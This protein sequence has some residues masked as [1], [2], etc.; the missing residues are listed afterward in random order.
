MIDMLEGVLRRPKT[1][2]VL[3]LALLVAG[4]F[5]YISIPKEDSPDIDVPIFYVSVGQQGISPEDAERLLVRP[6]ETELRGLDGLKEITA[7][8]SEGHAAIILEFDISFDKDE[9]LS[10]VRDKVDAAKGELPA[11]A[12]EPTITETNFAL[13]PTITIALSGSVP[14]RTLYQHARRLKDVVEAIDTV[15]S[16]DLKGHREELLE[17]LIDSQKL[18]SYAITQQELLASLSENNQLVPAGYIDGGQGR[19]N[20][21]VPGLVETALDVY[22]LPIKQSGEGVVTLRDVAD[23]RRTFKDADSYTRVNGQPAIALDVTKRIGTNIIENNIAIRAAVDEATKDWPET[24]QVDYM[25][26]MSSNIFE[27]LGSLQSSIMTA[28]F[29][30]MILVLAALGLRS[31][32]LVGLAIPTSFMVGFLILSGLGYTVNIMV[33]F[34]LVLTVGML[35]DGAIVMV[36]YA[37]RKVSEGMEDREAFIRAARLMFWPIVSSTATTLVAFLPMLLWPGVAGEFMSY[38]PIMVIIVLTAALLTAMVFLPVTGGIFA[39]ITHFLNRYAAAVLAVLIAAVS[40]VA[41]LGFFGVQ[42]GSPEFGA[43][44]SAAPLAIPAAALVLLGVGIGSFLVLRPFVRRRKERTALQVDIESEKPLKRYRSVTFVSLAFEAV[45]VGFGAYFAFFLLSTRPDIVVGPITSVFVFLSGL[46]QPLAA[47]SNPIAIDVGFYLVVAGLTLL[48]IWAGYQAISPLVHLCERLFGGVRTKLGFNAED[49]R[50]ETAKPDDLRFDPSTA[51]GFTGLYVRHLKLLAGNPIG[52]VLTIVAVLGACAYI[53]TSFATNPTG[54]EFFVD[55]EPDQAV[56]LVS[57]RGNMS[58]LESFEIV[59]QVEAEVLQTTGIQNVITSAFPPGG[60]SGPDFIGGVQDKP[61]DVIG[62]MTLELAKYCC[63]RTAAEIFAEIRDRTADIP[64]VKVETRKIEGGPPTG[65]DIQLEVKSTDYD[66]MVAEVARIRAHLDQME[67][68]LDQEDDR[69]LPGIEWQIAIDREQA[70]RYQA[71]IGSVGAM[72]QLVTNGVLI[73]K[74]RPTDSE[75]EVDIRVRLPSDERTLD[76]FDQLRLQ[77]PLGLVP[78]ANFVDRAPEPKVSSITRRDGLYSMMLKATVDKAAMDEDGKPITVDAKVQELT[79]W[80][81]SQAFPDNVYLQFRGADEDQKES[82]EFLMRAMM[83]SLFLMF[84]ILLT[85]FNSFYQTFL[86]LSTVV[87]SVMGVLLGMMLTGQKF[88]IIM[89][90]TGIVALAGIV[91]NNAIVLIDTYNRFRHDGFEPL[92]AILKTSGQRIRP[93]LLTTVTTIVGLIPMATAVNLDFFTQTV[94]VGG[95]TAIWW[96]QLSTAVIFGLAFS[97]VLTLIMIPVM[98]AMP[99][100]WINSFTAIWSWA[101]SRKSARQPVS[102]ESPDVPE[103]P[104]AG[105]EQDVEWT[106]PQQEKERPAAQVVSM[107]KPAPPKVPPQKETPLAAE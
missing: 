55:E 82:G 20:V 1:V 42:P 104:S 16:A 31:A 9:A 35:V 18:E 29:L 75:D 45:A 56:V 100:T 91:V 89:T 103:A 97:T 8:A 80:L 44:I 49:G 61:G 46:A 99:S 65:K 87:M 37:D 93:I 19:F 24:I 54:V 7:I 107:P 47:L 84:L 78:I 4:V 53:F 68:L 102:D 92:D 13:V 66:T 26:D 21:K 57:A 3:M 33:M 90:G 40:S 39:A 10:D 32:L 64:G 2:F 48:A 60:G 25:I 6:M 50:T 94:A 5:S 83:A 43:Q 23:I 106:D 17:V 71:G 14:E 86:T 76:R 30:V 12:D 105:L 15:R 85:Q 52:N 28:I 88:S 74:Y 41:T 72:V 79:A 96:I 36:E 63:R 27:V 11:D 77:T 69:P 34:G 51:S 58:A 59:Q 67:H 22:S 38:L 70:G 62:E 81:D 98:I 95:I 73:G 101:M